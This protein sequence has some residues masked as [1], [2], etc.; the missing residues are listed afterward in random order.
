MERD[1]TSTKKFWEKINYLLPNKEKGN[2][3]R[4]V[5]KENDMVIGDKD[6]PDYINKFFTGIGPKLANRFKEAWVSDLQ[7]GPIQVGIQDIIKV[8]KDINIVKASTVPHISANVLK[9]AFMIIP[10]QLCFMYNLS[11]AKGIYPDAWKVANVIPL[12]KWGDPT[13]VNNLR[14]VSL[15]PLP[16]KIAERLMHTHLSKYIEDNGLLSNKQGGFRKG[17]STISTVAEL[18]DDISLGVNNREYTIA[19]FIDLKKAFDTINHNILLQKLPSFGLNIVIINWIQNYL[20][21]RKQ[22]CSVN[23]MTSEE[24]DII[25]GVPQGSILGPLLFLLYVNDLGINLLHSNVLLYADDTVLF[26]NHKDERIAQIWVQTDLELLSKWCNRNQLTINLAKT[27]LMLFGTRNM[28]KHCT[29]IDIEIDNQNLQYVKQF[30]Y[31]GIKLEDTLTFELHAAETMRMVS[32]KLYLLSRVRKYITIGQSIAVYKSKVV[33]YFDYGDIFLSNISVKTVD[34]LQK[35]QNRALRI[36]LARNGRSNVN[37]LHNTCN[38]NKLTHR[39]EAHLLN[40][41]YKRACIPRYVQGGC[42]NL[43]RFDAPILKEI[44]SNNKCFERSI[45]FQGALAWNRQSVE[46]RNT[47]THKLFKKKQKCKLNTLLPYT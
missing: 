11:F 27:K 46:D 20:S 22:K 10:L 4:L 41:V 39:R 9:D 2:T 6:L 24:R 7:I 37:D 47:A 21:N 38:V 43:R 29:K 34:K 28:L 1:E 12:K 40:F 17:R 44:K 18:T 45:N 5:D 35:L 13:D 31:L 25:C 19:S 23:G 42:R 33:P 16:G 14:P 3:I 8:V 26:A 30:N 36:C 32:Y 15:L